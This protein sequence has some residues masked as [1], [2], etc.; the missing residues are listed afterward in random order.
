MPRRWLSLTVAFL[1]LIPLA[2][3]GGEST[4]DAGVK[5]VAPSSAAPSS[6]GAPTN[7]DAGATPGA[8]KKPA[9]GSFIDYA[10]YSGDRARYAEGKVVLFFHATWCPDCQKTEKNLNADPADIPDNLTIVKVDFDSAD[11]LKKKY[12]ITQQFTFVSISPD[13]DQQKKWTGTYTA[14]TIAAKA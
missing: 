13:G 6:E 9:A 5:A 10:A 3:C 2:A 14:D 8:A 7:A 12:G 1:T 11:D 4:G